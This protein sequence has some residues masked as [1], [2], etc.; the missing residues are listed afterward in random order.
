MCGRYRLSRRKEPL[1]EYFD[2][3]MSDLDW[4]PRFNI[5]PSQPVPVVRQSSR[6]ETPRMSLVRWGLIPS[7][8]KD[9]SIG[10]HTINHAKILPHSHPRRSMIGAYGNTGFFSR[11]DAQTRKSQ[12]GASHFVRSRPPYG[13]R[14]AGQTTATHHSDVYLLA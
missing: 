2:A 13:I 14:S 5:A 8:A 9:P 11:C 1:A 6:E 12:L 10:A 7:W 4:E 3:D